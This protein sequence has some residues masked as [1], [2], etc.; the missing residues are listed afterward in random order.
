MAK[1][2]LVSKFR[3]FWHTY[4]KHTVR[5]RQKGFTLLELLVVTLIAGGIVSGLTYIVVELLTADQREASRTETQQDMQAAMDYISNE[6]REAV[7]VY[8]GECLQT[9]GDGTVGG[10]PGLIPYL[11]A[12]VSSQSV[13]VIAFWKQEPLPDAVRNQCAASNGVLQ[14]GGQAVPC[15]TAHSYSLVVYSLSKENTSNNWRGRARITRYALTEFTNAG[16]R[17]SG[18]VNPG[19]YNNFESWPFGTDPAGG[20]AIV[21]LQNIVT[22]GGRPT[23]T[24]VV[25]TDFVDDG[26]GAQAIGLPGTPSCPNLGTSYSASPT[27][28][29]LSS[30]GF[31][32]VRSFYACV[33][34]NTSTASGVTTSSTPRDENRD[35]ILFLRGN[36]YGKAGIVDD[37][38]FLP[39]LETR[40]LS[41]GVLDRTP[42]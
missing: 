24:P 17:N 15:L 39:T 36:A 8:K 3:Q 29:S 41:R 28:T 7:Y 34:I 30:L 26:S 38:G 1:P 35:M 42:N 4:R 9:G 22:P 12:S 18:Y 6:L 21:N 37:R 5:D 27:N 32:N 16:Q 14:V 31:A 13:P 20:G 23:G 25:L 10:C 40:V 19:V 2:S 33:S 11:P